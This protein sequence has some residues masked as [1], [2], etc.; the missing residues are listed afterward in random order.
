MLANFFSR[1]FN[2]RSKWLMI[3]LIF[4]FFVISTAIIYFKFYNL[5]SHQDQ[6]EQLNNE[7][8]TIK[9]QMLKLENNYKNIHD[10]MSTLKTQVTHGVIVDTAPNKKLSVKRDIE[11]ESVATLPTLSIQPPKPPM[12]KIEPSK[13][14]STQLEPPKPQMTALEAV[15][16]S[17]TPSVM[18]S[19]ANQSQI[20]D[21]FKNQ[22]MND[23][24]I[25]DEIDQ[26][27]D[28]MMNEDTPPPMLPSNQMNLPQM[29][30][31][32]NEPHKPKINKNDNFEV[33]SALLDLGIYK[34]NSDLKQLSKILKSNPDEEEEEIQTIEDEE[35]Y[36]EQ[37]INNHHSEMPNKQTISASPK[38]HSNLNE[39]LPINK[40]NKNQTLFLPVN[41]TKPTHQI[42]STPQPTAKKINH[43]RL[44]LSG[45]G[46]V[47]NH[48]SKNYETPL[49]NHSISVNIRSDPP[50]PGRLIG[51]TSPTDSKNSD[52]D[53]TIDLMLSSQTDNQ[54]SPEIDAQLD[55]FKN[56]MMDVNENNI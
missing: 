47:K 4:C 52:I 43:E 42:L 25:N 34:S 21:Q 31:I 20:K 39:S 41:V 13:P 28:E 30:I 10:N 17:A 35:K 56:N 3:V 45:P 38:T 55:H 23:N 11:T 9:T 40:I 8:K 19:I 46:P 53:H 51:I 15:R 48:Q 18:V 1:L 2:L 26:D 16:A 36:I 7:N 22:T 27:I 5:D 37:T 50:T 32:Q 14:Q 6:I 29:V 54:T 12:T 33:T 24:R 44:N 49:K